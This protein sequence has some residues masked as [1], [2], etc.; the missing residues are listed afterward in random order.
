V[1]PVASAADA[2]VSFGES[3]RHL[4]FLRRSVT[5]AKLRSGQGRVIVASI[6]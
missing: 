6:D 4:A 1:V 3:T 5:E 2:S